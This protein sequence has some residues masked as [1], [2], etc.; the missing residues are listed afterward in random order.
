MA[1]AMRPYISWFWH[2]QWFLRRNFSGGDCLDLRH[3]A[4]DPSSLE[5]LL[6]YL[7]TL[8]LL[9]R[10]PPG[11]WSLWTSLVFCSDDCILI[12]TLDPIGSAMIPAGPCRKEPSGKRT[13]RSVENLGRRRWTLKTKKEPREKAV[14]HSQKNNRKHWAPS[15]K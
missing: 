3:T 15:S 10:L 9:S 8:W 13:W 14:L 7:L 4:V 6:N 11:T 1:Q 5:R 2:S 12:V